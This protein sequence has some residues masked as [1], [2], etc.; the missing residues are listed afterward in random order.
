MQHIVFGSSITGSL[1]IALKSHENIISFPDHLDVGPVYRLLSPEGQQLRNDWLQKAYRYDEEQLTYYNTQ[2]LKAISQIQKLD[3]QSHVLIWTCENAAEQFGL[4][5]VM[6]LLRDKAC[7]ISVCNTYFNV[8]TSHKDRNTQI[9]I[10]HSGEL[11]SKQLAGMLEQ[12]L[13]E[14]ISNEQKTVYK[15]EA[16]QLLN[17]TSLLRTWHRGQLLEDVESRDDADILYYARELQDE[18]TPSEYYIA[19]RLIGHCL[20]HSEHDI[21]DT[22]IDYRVRT[23]IA[24]G[25]LDYKGDLREM[26]TYKVRA[27]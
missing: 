20:G 17:S 10:R 4:R 8:L 2:L 12:H 24:Q 18:L 11:C 19:A 27:K 26:R 5:L 16:A 7:T 13:F 15:Q 23:L 22:W 3:D 25:K 14:A 6:Y 21:S 1:Q 9:L